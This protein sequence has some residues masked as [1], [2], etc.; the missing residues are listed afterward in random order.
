MLKDHGHQYAFAMFYLS[1]I[2]QL[3]DSAGFE[4]SQ[5]AVAMPLHPSMKER[6]AQKPRSN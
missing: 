6:D 3:H 1:V 4:K 2:I 5:C